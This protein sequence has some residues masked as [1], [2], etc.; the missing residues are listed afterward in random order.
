MPLMFRFFRNRHTAAEA[1]ALGAWLDARPEN[2]EVF[3]K[4]F[5]LFQ[6]E[7]MLLEKKEGKRKRIFLGF[8]AAAAVAAALVG[9]VF[10]NRELAT[11]P[12]R[13]QL[14][15]L[16]SQV[17]VHQTAPGDRVKLTLPDGSQVHLNAGSRLEHYSVYSGGERRVRLSG[18]ALFEV[19][20]DPAH[21]FVVETFSHEVTATG[22]RF[23]VT[24]EEEDAEFCT[25]LMQGSVAIRD[26]RSGE[27]WDIRPGQTALLE[28]GGLLIREMEDPEEAALWSKGII[29]VSGIP[30]DRLMR[31]FE[32]CFGVSIVIDRETLPTVRYGMAKVR[33]SNGIGYALSVLQ[34]RSDFQYRYDEQTQTY[35]IY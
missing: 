5:Q 22:T 19:K 18:E 14:A 10:L 21:P 8:A 20:S 15:A 35:H 7:E 23:N 9:G 24:A 16:E 32:R 25:T 6:A 34:K 29:S 28:E 33:V 3:R 27:K 13:Q 1:D 2:Q 12:A 4:A 31:T 17:T 30:F 26:S 11:K